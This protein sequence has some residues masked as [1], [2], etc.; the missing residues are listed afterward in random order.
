MPQSGGQAESSPFREL[1]ADPAAHT[2]TPNGGRGPGTLARWLD[3]GSVAIARGGPAAPGRWREGFENGAGP[4]PAAAPAPPGRPRR[5][6]RSA[7]L[8]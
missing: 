2:H 3:V 1:D 8:P 7:R 5:R 4:T 6:R